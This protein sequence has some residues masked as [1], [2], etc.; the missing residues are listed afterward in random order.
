MR[1]TEDKIIPVNGKNNGSTISYWKKTLKLPFRLFFVVLAYFVTGWLGLQIPY[2]GS[3]I[4]L[5]WLPTGI[6]VAALLLWGRPVLLSIYLGAFLINF[7]VSHSFPL[8]A[9]IAVGNT[10]GPFLVAWM[11][12]YFGLDFSFRHSKDSIMLLLASG[13]GMTVSALGGVI[14][15]YMFGLLPLADM[16][17]AWLSWWMGDSIGVILLAPFILAISGENLINIRKKNLEVLIWLVSSS[18]IAFI[19]FDL[20]SEKGDQSY[21]FEFFI[22][23]MIIWASLRFG[24]IG[25]S[26]SGL[27]FSIIAASATAIGYG[28][29]SF[30]DNHIGLLRLWSFIVT[31]VSAGLLISVIQANQRQADE[32]IKIK[33]LELKVH[34]EEIKTLNKNSALKNKTLEELN[35]TKDKFFSIIAHDL[36]SPFNS[37]IGLSELLI[38][39]IRDKD[40]DDIDEYAK[41]IMQS[42]H[43]AMDLL[44]NLMEWSLSQTGRMKFNPEYFELNI[45]INDIIQ[46]FTDI[47][48]QK[49]IIITKKLPPNSSIYAD[50]AMISTILRNL[51][52]NAIKYTKPGGEI[53][54]LSEVTQIEMKVSVSDTGV[55]MSPASINKL[56]LIDENYSTIGTLGE[57]GTGLGLILINE[58]VEKHFGKI[59]VESVEG[60][61]SIFNFTIPYNSEP[62]L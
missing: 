58:F 4:T 1:V 23:P 27:F 53:N 13:L 56:F 12:K 11:L 26:F 6:A 43:R 10:L 25:G 40:F 3:Q 32:K 24:I 21:H 22:L 8:S 20:F 39:K 60:K 31:N 62:Q 41:I 59:W 38:K 7:Y 34:L 57:Q 47:A 18:I 35:A 2:V 30:G 50:K 49:S 44:L 17:F 48:G 37:I 19:S 9:S 46:L 14:C 42:S 55:G 28:G 16:S 54:I 33:N 45:I 52:S 29:F 5:I 15:L 61:G 51:I 36:K